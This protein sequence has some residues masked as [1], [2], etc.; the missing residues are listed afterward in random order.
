[1]APSVSDIYNAT[2]GESTFMYDDKLP[3][4]PVPDL[5]STLEKYLRS[6][7][8]HV[9]EEQFEKTKQIVE[10]FK[11]GVGRQLQ[12]LLVAKGKRERNWVIAPCSIP[13]SLTHFACS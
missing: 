12:E 4:L 9:T 6:T 2:E 5:E 7:K 13:L 1:M 8:P 10:N 3:S 11:N